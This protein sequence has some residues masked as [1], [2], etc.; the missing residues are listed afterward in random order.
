[1]VRTGT[2]SD[3]AK[4]RGG[5]AVSCWYPA[6]MW[7]RYRDLVVDDDVQVLSR[8]DALF[9]TDP[10]ARGVG[11]RLVSW[12]HGDA[13]VSAEVTE[14][15][16]NFMGVTHGGVIFTIADIAMSV[17]SNSFGRV[18]L[19]VRLDISYLRGT[20]PGDQLIAT[21]TTTHTSRRFGHHRLDLTRGDELVAQ[22][23]G[24]TYRTDEWHF[25]QQSWPA[26]WPHD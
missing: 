11:A 5:S 7:R 6:V 8:L 25:G 10:T 23:S 14:Q 20:R 13:V 17:A 16:T 12:G 9:R 19:A 26:D 4:V 15:Q 3:S 1:M 21:A 18:A 24:T 22:A 2:A